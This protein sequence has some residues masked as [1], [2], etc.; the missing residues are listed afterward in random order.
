MSCQVAPRSAVTN[1]NGSSD[2][3][4][5][6]RQNHLSAIWLP[7]SVVGRA[8]DGPSGLSYDWNSGGPYFSQPE[9]K[10]KHVLIVASTSKG[11]TL[12]TQPVPSLPCS[13]CRIGCGLCIG[14]DMLHIHLIH[15][16]QVGYSAFHAT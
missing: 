13:R 11:T 14:V 15:L 12:S 10:T 3:S 9:S 2:K 5:I 16:K 4:E 7:C 8:H 1:G 6:S